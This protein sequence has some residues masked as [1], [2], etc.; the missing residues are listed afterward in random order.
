MLDLTPL[1]NSTLLDPHLCLEALKCFVNFIAKIKS[2]QPTALEAKIHEKAATY[3]SNTTS[4]DPNLI[5]VLRVVLQL[6]IDHSSVVQSLNEKGLV[7][8]LADVRQW[9][10][11]DNI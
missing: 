8:H 3:L 9:K 6:V 7:S 1:G 4:K 10:F 5:P 2:F 11:A